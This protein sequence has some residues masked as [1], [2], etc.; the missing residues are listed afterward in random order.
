MLR[1]LFTTQSHSFRTCQNRVLK[2]CDLLYIWSLTAHSYNLLTIYGKRSTED[3]L[4]WPKEDRKSCRRS[5]GE[6]WWQDVTL[7]ESSEAA[8]HCKQ[9]VSS[10]SSSCNVMQ[11]TIFHLLIE[12]LTRLIQNS[13]INQMFTS[14]AVGFKRQMF[15][16]LQRGFHT[17]V[18]SLEE[19]S[20][21]FGCW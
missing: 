8:A 1:W 12:L 2:L 13:T 7:F 5:D 20:S 11:S 9:K 10:F 4:L 17:S 15:C 16:T 6:K 21:C 19:G 18:E 3:L 14:E